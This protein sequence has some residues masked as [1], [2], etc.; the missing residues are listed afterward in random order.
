MMKRIMMLLLSVL[1]LSGLALAEEAVTVMLP[2][3]TADLTSFTQAETFSAQ[4]QGYQTVGWNVSAAD[5]HAFERFLAAYKDELIAQGLDMVKEVRPS[6]LNAV[7]YFFDHP[8]SALVSAKM[9]GIS[10]DLFMC[11]ETSGSRSA[12]VM[13]I[14]PGIDLTEPAQAESWESVFSEEEPVWESVLDD[15]A[16]DTPK[17][18][19]IPD[20]ASYA[21]EAIL[22]TTQEQGRVTYTLAVEDMS[23]L[24]QYMMVLELNYGVSG[25]DGSEEKYGLPMYLVLED[26]EGE[27]EP[28]R[29][30]IMLASG[31]KDSLAGYVFFGMNE[32]DG[33]VHLTVWYAMGMNP[34]DTDDRWDGVPLEGEALEAMQQMFFR[35]RSANQV[36][37]FKNEAIAKDVAYKLKKDV[38]QITWSDVRD[39]HDLGVIMPTNPDLSDVENMSLTKFALYAMT[40]EVIDLSCLKNSEYLDDIFLMDGKYTGFDTLAGLEWLDTVSL[41]AE[42]ITDISWLKD[43]KLL[44]FVEIQDCSVTDFSALATLPRLKQ[45]YLEITL[46]D[47]VSFLYGKG[48][49]FGE[50]YGKPTS[51]FDEWYE[52]NWGKP[53]E[54]PTVQP[55]AKPTVKPADNKN[56]GQRCSACGGDGYREERCSRCGGDGNVDSRCSNCGGDGDRDCMSCSGKGYDNC[57]GCYGS[58]DRRC[59]SCYGTGKDGD[60]R[61]F[62]CGG[63]GEKNCS[64]C[65]GTGKKRCSA[66]SGTGDRDCTYCGGDGTK[67]QSCSSCGGDGRET[68]LCSSCGGDGKR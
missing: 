60:K 17:E 50:T 21:Q 18:N 32:H 51:T 30:T 68:S 5:E 1:F 11:G 4:K 16:K 57:S 58:G 59:G 67:D 15:P 19:V 65:S 39:Y 63:D 37:P 40:S 9:N 6:G 3:D 34:A 24:I 29:C 26:Y 52:H 43:K 46:K 56:D 54:E 41:Q 64:S 62:S 53:G 7:Y 25:Q 66:C 45:V 49:D 35:A 28:D 8:D 14:V 61:C 55:T 36:Y 27:L 44:R 23:A 47:D 48:L 10:F 31:E 42:S 2:R 12:M 38:A 13:G 22:S 33:Q 20:F